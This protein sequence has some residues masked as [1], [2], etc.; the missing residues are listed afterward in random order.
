MTTPRVPSLY[1]SEIENFADYLACMGEAVLYGGVT[2]GLVGQIADAFVA[3]GGRL[4]GA[5]IPEEE[6][7]QHPDLERIHRF[8]TY[9]E[10]QNFMFARSER[11][12]FLPGGLGTFHEF[13]SLLLKH[14]MKDP[15]L[16]LEQKI[17][18][19]NWK[20]FWNPVFSLLKES[21]QQGFLGTMD[22]S[23]IVFL[24]SKS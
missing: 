15:A 2:T 8:A 3:K 6:A 14:K 19:L 9:D 16:L 1:K 5:L 23:K 17:V 20:G 21:S 11:V 18:L 12:F 10:R 4:E 24:E 22:F 13:F 7:D